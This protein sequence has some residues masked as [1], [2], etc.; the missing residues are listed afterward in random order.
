VH[1][2]PP[3][4]SPRCALPLRS[5]RG[6]RPRA[7]PEH[8]RARPRHRRF[9]PSM[10]RRPRRHHPARDEGRTLVARRPMI[11]W[12]RPVSFVNA[13]VVAAPGVGRADVDTIRFGSRILS[14]GEA[15]KPG[16]VVVDLHGAMV[17]PGLINAHDHLELN[18]YGRIA[19]RNTYGNVSEW[20]ADMDGRLSGDPAIR[21]G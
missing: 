2:P 12:T 20:I 17:L 5:S 10:G 9:P 4:R 16:D 13:Q 11:P 7:A 19:D 15:P 18:H 6:V 1:S 21:A 8:R 14:V 3:R